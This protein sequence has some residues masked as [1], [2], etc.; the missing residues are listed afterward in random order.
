MADLIQKF[1]GSSHGQQAKQSLLDQGFSDDEATSYL[2]H[3]AQ[4][5]ADHVHEHAES[6][7]LL[8]DHPGRNFFAAFAAGIVK[9]DGVFA[10]LGDGFEGVL[11]GRITE[12]I[13][14][15]TGID[16]NVALRFPPRQLPSWLPS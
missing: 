8:G 16:S 10:S 2:S 14:N 11:T 5:G 7:G 15:K 13:C 9:G 12:A 6:H 1:L 4:A 3:A